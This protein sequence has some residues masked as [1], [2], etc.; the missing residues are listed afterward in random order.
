MSALVK[1][2]CIRAF[3]NFFVW[4]FIWAVRKRLFPHKYHKCP[5]TKG[6]LYWINPEKIVYVS[7]KEFS[8]YND[9]DKVLDGDWDILDRKFEK[10]DFYES[11]CER[12]RDKK[13]WHETEYYKRVLK[14]I[15]EG[16]S[17]IATEKELYEHCKMWD[18]TYES[19]KKGGYKPNKMGDEITVNIGRHGDLLFN[20][21]RHRLA[22]CKILGIKKI[23]VEITVRHSKWVEFK[24]EILDYAQK[25]G[26]Y[27]PLTHIDLQS[28]PSTHGDKRFKLIKNN[29]S[30]EKG[31]LLDIG[32]HWGYFCHKFEEE[33]FE[34]YSVENDPT[35]LYF[36][37]K[38]KQ[39]ENRRFTIV[40]ES[41]FS[42]C[43]K[44]KIKFDVVLALAV[45]H[46]FLKE[47]KTFYQLIELLEE[48]NM[49][50]MFF[51][52]HLPDEA[53]MKRAFKNFNCEE[54]VEFILEHSCL[55][56]SKL[57]GYAESKRPVYK[58][59]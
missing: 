57:I 4:R 42:F 3:I 27:A 33:G 44:T 1:S 28:I 11:F 24:N 22:F 54:F 50:A 55:T 13:E 34:C 20:N 9:D 51:Q 37:R 21:G 39:A 16:K 12:I 26:I 6:Q 2:R 32:S 30:V 7:R 49:K 15:S 40:P 5:F 29:L 18:S 53:G 17:R 31:T 25:H 38:L 43:K 46:H 41:I 35:C 58:L 48:L 8:I 23:P 19:I 52:P 14:E 56:K 10:I 36:L 47:K 45:F 59:Y